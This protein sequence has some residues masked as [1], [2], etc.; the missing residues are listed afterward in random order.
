MIPTYNCAA[1]LPNTLASVLAQDPGPEEMQI[2]V[3]DDCS[4]DNPQAIVEELAPGRVAFY[5]QHQN[6]GHVSNFNTCIERSSGH[7][8]HLLHG[9]DTVRDGFY[10]TIAQP[11]H[12]HPGIGAAFC[13]H[14]YV[15]ENG[16]EGPVARLHEPESGIFT[17]AAYRI[18]ADVGIQPPAVVIRRSVYEQLGGFDGRL[19]VAGEDME[20]WV[21]VAASYPVWYAIEPLALYHRRAGSLISGSMRS[22]VAIRDYRATIDLLVEHLDVDRR[23]SAY[24]AAR[25]RCA[26]WA[27]LQAR[28]LTD[29]GDR[30]A[31]FVQLREA[32]MSEFSPHVAIRAA[33]TIA[34]MLLTGGRQGAQRG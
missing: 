18:A 31:A 34:R 23:A 22:G 20:M 32:V 24:R 5:R 6:V 1:Y 29:I 14:V 21:R 10:C 17:D 26:D 11:F 28:E 3:I 33:K 4:S 16:R 19:R 12:D 8:V 15:D 25:R 13:R 27:L 2:E 7:L 30:T 9:D